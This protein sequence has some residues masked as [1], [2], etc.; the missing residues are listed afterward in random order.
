MFIVA[1][2]MFHLGPDSWLPDAGPGPLTP[3]ARLEQNRVEAIDPY[4]SVMLVGALVAITL[5]VVALRRRAPAPTELTPGTNQ[6]P[7]R[8]VGLRA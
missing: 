6:Y 5:I 7:N 1:D 2:I 3:Q 4:V 8:L